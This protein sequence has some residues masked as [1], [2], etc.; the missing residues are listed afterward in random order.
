M[1]RDTN[2]SNTAEL[3]QDIDEDVQLRE[4]LMFLRG[5]SVQMPGDGDPYRLLAEK[6]VEIFSSSV[7]SRSW[8]EMALVIIEAVSIGYVRLDLVGRT[9]SLSTQTTSMLDKIDLIQ[10][11]VCSASTVRMGSVHR[12]DVVQCYYCDHE[13]GVG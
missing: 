4:L 10:C 8:R 12:P 9:F 5:K 6:M 11:S 7:F 3:L 2:I 13:V 1:S